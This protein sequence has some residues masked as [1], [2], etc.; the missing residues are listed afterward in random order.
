M[1]RL[2]VC[3]LIGLGAGTFAQAFRGQKVLSVACG[4]V[5]GCIAW[6]LSSGKQILEV[7]ERYYSARL[8]RREWQ[9]KTSRVAIPTTEQIEKY[10]VPYRCVDR[11]SH[12]LAKE[13]ERLNASE[14]VAD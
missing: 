1:V 11:T 9:D 4:L 14:F 13:E 3:I 6:A 8:K 5:A 10:G 7:V 12:W 2:A